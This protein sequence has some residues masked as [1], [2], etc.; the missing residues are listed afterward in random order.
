[1]AEI[2]GFSAA[3]PERRDASTQGVLAEG[4]EPGSNILRFVFNGL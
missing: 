1:M 4:E 3:I 2:L